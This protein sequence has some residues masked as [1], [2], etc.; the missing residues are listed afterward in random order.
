MPMQTNI[1]HGT[2]TAA[3]NYAIAPAEVKAIAMMRSC[4]EVRAN[5]R[6]SPAPQPRYQ[7]SETADA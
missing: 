6:R 4:C 3:I 7:D 2:M 1:H 5:C